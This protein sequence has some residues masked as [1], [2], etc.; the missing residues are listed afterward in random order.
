MSNVIRCIVLLVKG[1]KARH[2]PRVVLSSYL[3]ENVVG[4]GVVV[5]ETAVIPFSSEVICG[6]SGAGPDS[7]WPHPK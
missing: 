6:S 7:G 1:G 5:T 3:Q 2:R 4:Q